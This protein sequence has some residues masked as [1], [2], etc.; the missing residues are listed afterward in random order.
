MPTIVSALGKSAV[1]ATL[2]ITLCASAQAQDAAPSVSNAF[3]SASWLVT[4]NWEGRGSGSAVFTFTA[5]NTNGGTFTTSDG[6]RGRFYQRAND[7]RAVLALSDVGGG[8]PD[9]SVSYALTVADDGRSF[10]GINGHVHTSGNPIGT[11]TAIRTRFA[12]DPAELVT[13]LGPRSQEVDSAG[14]PVAKKE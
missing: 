13:L 2:V 5:T 8:V 6:N 12:K 10:S 14:A 1:C 11:H 9:W 3:K 7:P 4:F